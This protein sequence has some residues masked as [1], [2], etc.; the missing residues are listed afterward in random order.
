[1]PDRL[2]RIRE[3][4]SATPGDAFLQYALATELCNAGDLAAGIAAYES[5]RSVH[6]D[7]LG[8]YYH[9]GATLL[10]IGRTADADVVF[11]DGIAR[12]RAAGDQHTLS[13]LQNIRL[14]AQLDLE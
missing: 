12:S 10:K 8:L 5:L 1:M 3:M 7:Y 2:Q 14:N 6:P 13:E 9:L 11:A 4:L